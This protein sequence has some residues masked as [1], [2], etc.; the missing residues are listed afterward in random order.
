VFDTAIIESGLPADEVKTYLNQLD[1][2]GRPIRYQRCWCRLQAGDFNWKRLECCI[3]E[4]R[5]PI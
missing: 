2:L 3:S 4:A 1:G 5:T